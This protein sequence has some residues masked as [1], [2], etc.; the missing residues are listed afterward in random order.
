MGADGGTRK[1]IRSEERPQLDI[2]PTA[3]FDAAASACLDRVTFY[4]LPP[5]I[6]PVTPAR[7][8]QSWGLQADRVEND[9]PHSVSSRLDEALDRTKRS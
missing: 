3:F 2:P 9:G 5:T 7:R 8:R 4:S 6:S 1:D